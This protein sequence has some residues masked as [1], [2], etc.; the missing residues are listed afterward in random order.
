MGGQTDQNLGILSRP[1]QGTILGMRSFQPAPLQ[2][3]Q[4]LA[5]GQ[6]TSASPEE[7]ICV[8]VGGGGVGSGTWFTLL[9]DFQVTLS[10]TI[11]TLHSTLA[12]TEAGKQRNF[13]Q[14]NGLTCFPNVLLRIRHMI[15]T[16]KAQ[17][18]ISVG[19]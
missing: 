6:V 12:G 14:E 10:L 16:P 11:G 9:I 5:R 1:E 15:I 4:T 8:C 2:D 13:Q 18:S 19:E 3:W 7:R 17:G